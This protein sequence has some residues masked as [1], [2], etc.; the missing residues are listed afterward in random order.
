MQI[1]IPQFQKDL[2]IKSGDSR[3]KVLDNAIAPPQPFFAAF[4]TP[5][6]WVAL[7]MA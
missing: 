7:S 1:H 2:H 6:K 4:A 5:G 3:P